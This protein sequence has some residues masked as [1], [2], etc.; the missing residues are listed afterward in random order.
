MVRCHN[1]PA[2]GTPTV[3][4]YVAKLSSAFR[5]LYPAGTAAVRVKVDCANGVGAPQFATLAA[6]LGGVL[7]AT[8]CNDGA[9]DVPV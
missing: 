8:L 4:G 5:A 9:F 1:D 6:S 3:E 2:Y 7:D